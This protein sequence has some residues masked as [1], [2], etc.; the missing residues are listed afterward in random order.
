MPG[1]VWSVEGGRWRVEGGELEGGV[2]E[3]GV[4]GL[5]ADYAGC[6]TARVLYGYIG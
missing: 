4:G 6:S 2:G 5:R 3:W 1:G